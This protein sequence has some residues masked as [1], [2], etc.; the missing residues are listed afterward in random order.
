MSLLVLLLLQPGCKM[1][2]PWIWSKVLRCF[3]D[4]FFFFAIPIEEL[5]EKQMHVCFFFLNWFAALHIGNL[6][7]LDSPLVKHMYVDRAQGSKYYIGI[8][9]CLKVEVYGPSNQSFLVWF[10]L[11]DFVKE[12]EHG[13]LVPQKVSM[14]LQWE[15]PPTPAEVP[16]LCVQRNR[17]YTTWY[18]CFRK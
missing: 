3:D 2:V 9:E 10:L 5:H 8:P 7:E 13:R 1:T 17:W 18:G 12:A 14:A 4:Q 11:G 16:W 15:R 6:W